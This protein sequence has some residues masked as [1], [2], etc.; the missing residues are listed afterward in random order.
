MKQFILITAMIFASI[1]MV[2]QNGNNTIALNNTDEQKT[3]QTT[4]KETEAA[5]EIK[6]A[7]KEAEVS[8]F[9]NNIL[10]PEV[11]AKTDNNKEGK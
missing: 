2:A 8:I 9:D 7:E 10:H 1:T 6:A 11:I 4:S 3:E 5:K